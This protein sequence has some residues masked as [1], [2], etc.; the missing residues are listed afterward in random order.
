V[1][2]SF[3]PEYAMRNALYP[4]QLTIESR[5]PYPASNILHPG[6]LSRLS[7]FARWVV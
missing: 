5:I 3:N 7:P 6:P 4:L 1:S 2:F